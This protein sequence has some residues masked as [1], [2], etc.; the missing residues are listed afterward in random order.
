LKVPAAHAAH[1]TPVCSASKPG[2]H[3]Q[4]SI[5]SRAAVSSSVFKGHAWHTLATAAPTAAE[6]VPTPHFAHKTFPLAVL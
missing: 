2:R 5:A 1:A 6:Y 3:T 4:F